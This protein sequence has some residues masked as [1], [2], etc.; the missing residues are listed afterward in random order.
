MLTPRGVLLQDA[1]KTTGMKLCEYKDLT[2][3]LTKYFQCML[4][5]VKESKLPLQMRGVSLARLE[6]YEE[7]LVVRFDA[8][9]Q[10]SF[11]WGMFSCQNLFSSDALLNGATYGDQC[12]DQMEEVCPPRRALCPLALTHCSFYL[13]FLH[14]L[15]RTVYHV[16][17]DLLRCYV[18]M[19][20]QCGH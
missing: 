4:E 8:V 2:H 18:W 3:H 17:R 20:F 7:D 5:A 14:V 13:Y 6:A 1:I 16:E 19:M 15:T 10:R 11:A 12:Q 9:K